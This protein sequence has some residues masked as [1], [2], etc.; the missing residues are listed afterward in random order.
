[1]KDITVFIRNDEGAKELMRAIAAAVQRENRR[2]K[3][4]GGMA[5]T[6]QISVVSVTTSMSS[7][8]TASNGVD[9]L[10]ASK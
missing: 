4:H 8:I 2:R 3:A 1:M 9:F 6:Y 5:A 10:K 7:K